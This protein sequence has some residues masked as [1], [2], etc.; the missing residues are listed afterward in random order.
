MAFRAAAAG[1]CFFEK[2]PALFLRWKSSVYN[3]QETLTVSDLDMF[4]VDFAAANG[5]SEAQL[6]GCYLQEA[7]SRKILSDL[8]EGF[9]IRVR[10]TPTYVIDGVAVSWYSDNLM[11]DYLRQ[12]YMKPGSSSKGAAPAV[13]K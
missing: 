8:T 13:K 12:T 11:E 10:A 3:R 9:A 6:K 4:A 2:D 1:R 7:S 5:V